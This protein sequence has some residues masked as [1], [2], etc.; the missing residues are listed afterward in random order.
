MIP[1]IKNKCLLYPVCKSKVDISCDELESYFVIKV[2]DDLNY[3]LTFDQILEYLPALY[4]IKGND[5]IFFNVQHSNKY[6]K[7]EIYKEEE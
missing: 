1:C 2:K 4:V 3:D 5:H 6:Y 7:E